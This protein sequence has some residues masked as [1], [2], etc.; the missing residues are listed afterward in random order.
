MSEGLP[1][2]I[3]EWDGEGMVPIPP[4]REKAD[5]AFVVGYRYRLASPDER[6]MKSHR[7]EFAWLKTAWNNLPEKYA[8]EPWA[9]T[10]EHLRKFALISTGWCE[11]ET[12][13]ASTPAEAYRMASFMGR[14]DE[15]A[16]TT[17]RGCIVCR[18]QA[19]SQSVKAMGAQ[20][21]QQ[22]KTDILGFVAALIGVTPKDLEDQARSEG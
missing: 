7:H 4:H 14:L 17:V 16:L 20:K 9:Q 8:G 13:V 10:T 12:F 19:V 11:S 2:L 5:K 1:L 6:S 18:F 3:Y 22:S 21:F 15:Y